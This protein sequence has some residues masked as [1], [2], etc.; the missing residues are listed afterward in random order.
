[1]NTIR[2]NVNIK[3]ALEAVLFIASN[4]KEVGFHTICKL[5]FYADEYHL[6]KYG[7]PVIGDNYVALQYGPVPTTIYDILKED[8]LLFEVLGE[9]NQPFIVQKVGSKPI[10]IPQRQAD[11]DYFSKSDI[12]AIKYAISK[13]ADLS[14]GELTEVSHS[15]PAWKNAGAC[16]QMN[17]EDFIDPNNIDLI[18]ELRENAQY[19]SI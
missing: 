10:V 16:S 8:P 15:H 4:C 2:F 12:E 7:R 1:M 3:K 14:F 18:N 11:L 9:E 17:Y 13:Y 19:L 6:N 5:C